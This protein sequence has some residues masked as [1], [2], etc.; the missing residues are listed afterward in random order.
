M[1]ELIHSWTVGDPGDHAIDQP[2]HGA[3]FELAPGQYSLVSDL[4]FELFLLVD[5]KP[6]TKIKLTN[7]VF[8]V[9]AAPAMYKITYPKGGKGW[10]RLSL[11]K[12]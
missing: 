12:G 5:D 2:R 6:D 1:S 7:G 3:Q 4:A 8:N 10:T 9:V 11:V